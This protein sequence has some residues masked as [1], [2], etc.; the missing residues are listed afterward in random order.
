MQTPPE[1][2][3][4]GIAAGDGDGDAEAGVNSSNNN[5][6][7]GDAARAQL[8]RLGNNN[9]NKKDD[10]EKEIVIDLTSCRPKRK[11]RS[12]VWTEGLFV[13]DPEMQPVCTCCQQRVPAGNGSATSNTTNLTNHY[14][15]KKADAAHKRKMEVAELNAARKQKMPRDVSESAKKVRNMR[16]TI[17]E[18]N[19]AV[20]TS[21]NMSMFVFLSTTAVLVLLY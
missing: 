15:S 12:I 20:N 9:N 10:S 17:N 14:K 19:T 13:L 7:S 6:V 11:G 16:Y 1:Q 18:Y 5:D 8:A 3:E 21:S 2:A 4:G